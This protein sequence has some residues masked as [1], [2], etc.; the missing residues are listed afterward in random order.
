VK[1]KLKPHKYQDEAI[2]F[3]FQKTYSINAFTMGLGKTLVG[4]GLACKVGAD[5]VLVICPAF[6]KIN[7]R[8]EIEKFCDSPKRFTIVSYDGVKKVSGKFGDYDCV[9]L[10][11]CHYIKNIKAKR[12]KLIHGYVAEHRPKFLLQL[13]GTPIKNRVPEFYSLLRLCW[14]G[15]KYP[16]F[17]PYAPSIWDFQNKFTKK[18]TI[19]FG[20]KKVIKFEGLKNPEQLRD[21]IKP[22]YLRR[23][24]EDV[25]DLPEQVH[26]DLVMED[27]ARTDSLLE[28]AWENYNSNGKKSESFMSGKAV[29]ALAKTQY[30]VDFIKDQ[31]ESGA[32]DRVIVFTDHVKAAK[33]IHAEFDPGIA[34]YVTGEVSNEQRAFYV[35]LINEGKIKVLVSTIGSLSV[36]VNITGVNCMIFNDFAWV[37]ADME[38]ARKRIHRIGQKNHCFYYYIYSSNMDKHIYKTLKKKQELIQEVDR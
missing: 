32:T 22:I 20:S 31:F 24:A 28:T 17:K 14:L 38:Q 25:L 23:K 33:K 29:N 4:I 27:K 12:T 37:E 8:Q 7:W 10:D 6:L 13:S 19:Y 34:K 3:A 11:E 1:L 35:D 15:G 30:T 36:G 16:E 21:L 26:T 2:E 18:K 9:I 5:K